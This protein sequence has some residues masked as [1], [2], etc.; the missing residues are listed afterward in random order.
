[1]HSDICIFTISSHWSSD[2]STA[3]FLFWISLTYLLLQ[4]SPYKCRR[5]SSHHPRRSLVSLLSC[6]SFTMGKYCLYHRNLMMPPPGGSPQ[7]PLCYLYPFCVWQPRPS[8]TSSYSLL[9]AHL[10]QTDFMVRW[11]D[12]KTVSQVT[13]TDPRRFRRYWCLDYKHTY[14]LFTQTKFVH[15]ICTSAREIVMHYPD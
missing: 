2:L 8:R 9:A 4:A 14:T 10:T 1:V 5:L 3:F 15:W 6:Y 7:A 13:Q 12:P 11:R